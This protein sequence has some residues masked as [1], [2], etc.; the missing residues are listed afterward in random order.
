MNEETGERER[1]EFIAK[2]KLPTQFGDFDV[3]AFED[4][5]MKTH[6]ALV[7]G[8]V[9][10]GESVLVRLHSRCLTGDAL[11]S[12]RCD[13]REQY[14]KAI[15][16]LE[17]QEKGILLY[18]NQ[19]GRGIGLANKIKAYSLQDEGLD[20]VQANHQLGFADDLRSYENAADMLKYL[21]VKSIALLSNNPKKIAGLRNE[22]IEIVKRM[23]LQIDSNEYDAA[24]LKTKREKMGHLLDEQE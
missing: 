9:E 18:M 14:E 12:M 16:Y 10:G 1:T 6:L 4:R 3:Y 19:E 5:K 15:K 13:C 24:Y 7:R 23:S 22:G 11:G 20:T 17:E 21:G 2:A 8:D